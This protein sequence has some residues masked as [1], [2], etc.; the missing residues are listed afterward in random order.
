MGMWVEFAVVH[1]RVDEFAWLCD[2]LAG[3]GW[4]HTRSVQR[5]VEAAK[6]AGREDVAEAVMAATGPP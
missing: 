6:T 3:D 2:R 1:E 5:M 4:S